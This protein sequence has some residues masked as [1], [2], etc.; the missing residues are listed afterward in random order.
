MIKLKLNAGPTL[1][2]SRWHYDEDRQE[3]KWVEREVTAVAHQFL[4][5]EVELDPALTLGDLF[6]L[7]DQDSVLQSV[8]KRSFVEEL[9][10]ETRKGVSP[11][12]TPGYA[13]E[14]IEYLELYRLWNFDTRTKEYQPMHRPDIHGIGFE[15]KAPLDEKSGFSYPAGERIQWG[16]SSANVRELLALPIRYRAEV[17][18][19]ED[20]IDAKNYGH[21]LDTVV[22]PYV[23]LGQVLNGTLWEL[24]FHGGPRAT[25]AFNDTLKEQMEDIENET[26]ETVSMEDLFEEHDRP[27]CEAL[28]ESIGT[29]RPHDVY[30]ALRAL[31][32]D[33]LVQPALSAAL[34]ESVLVKPEFATHPA[35]AFRKLF[36]EAK[37]AEES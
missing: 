20:D 3:G 7:L 6:K 12:Y 14:G 8:F 2:L 1:M 30:R 26:C 31:E 33:E 24:S 5:D 29:H 22:V 17:M 34:G 18:V 19:C 35:R 13:P 32:D 10:E 23:T 15:L 36:R 4:F 21:A 16:L 9:L 11:D 25:Q 27:G 28:F 37:L